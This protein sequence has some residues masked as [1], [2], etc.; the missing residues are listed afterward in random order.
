MECR[1]SVWSGGEHIA[2]IC[3]GL[4]MLARQGAIRLRQDIRTVPIRITSVPAHIA[5][6]RMTHMIVTINDRTTL[7]FDEHD[8]GDIDVE[9]AAQVDFY[10]KRSYRA[11]LIP[12]GVESKIFPLGLNYEVNADGIDRFEISRLLTAGNNTARLEDQARKLVRAFS[13]RSGGIRITES[14]MHA[15]PDFAVRPRV[16]FMAKAWDPEFVARGSEQLY[17]A[18]VAINEMRAAC[19]RALKANFGRDFL[20][21][22]VPSLF[23]RRH[24]PQLLL[25]NSRLSTK[26]GYINLLRGFPICVATTGLHESIGWK[27]AEYVAFSKAIVT[28]PLLFEVPGPFAEMDNYLTFDSPDN[29]VRSIEMLMKDGARR[30]TIMENNWNYYQQ[31]LRPD[32]LVW[33]TLSIATNRATT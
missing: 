10:F 13:L 28:E 20:G 15:S 19:I 12:K 18:T 33:R 25:A 5:D 11:A 14:R 8:A 27:L 1:M 26:R 3:A 29:A 32:R 4:T 31:Y 17:G 9:M 2:Q 30:Q 21:G 23:A 22:F 7:Y 24:Y 16:L 6:A